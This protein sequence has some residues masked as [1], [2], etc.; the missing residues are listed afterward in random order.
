MQSVVI[1]EALGLV[2]NTV[3][4]PPRALRGISTKF[5][6]AARNIYTAIGSEVVFWTETQQS[7][8]VEIRALANNS[9]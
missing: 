8:M 4:N 5:E 7:L 3:I 6:M 9:N 1:T 2:I